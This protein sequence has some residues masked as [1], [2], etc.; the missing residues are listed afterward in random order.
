MWRK[1][2]SRSVTAPAPAFGRGCGER[3]RVLEQGRSPS[4][5]YLLKPWLQQ[6]G[7]AVEALDSREPP[8]AGQIEAGDRVVIARYLPTAWRKLLDGRRE[9]LAGLA[10]FMDDDLFDAALLRELPKGYAQKIRR[11]A[12][13]HRNWFKQVRAELWVSTPVLA[14]KY[15]AWSPVLLPMAPTVALMQRRRSVRIAYH[16][17]ASH[18][19]EIEWL[20]GVL[21]QVLAQRPQVH[22]ELFGDITVHR[23]YRELPRVAVLH[24]MSW[25]NYLAYTASHRCDIGLAP[26]RPGRFNAARGPTK[27]WDYTRMGAAGLYADAVPYAGFVRD[28]VD[29]LLVGHEARAWVERIIELVDDAPLRASLSAAARERVLG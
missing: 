28:G 13:D 10:Y 24:P 17:T 16:G 2:L 21:S 11:L 15:A 26:L 1:L 29:G 12:T 18:I 25:E 5:D 8:R 7:F 6:R 19:G 3:V 9:Q 23:W 20:H 22:A 14:E 27:F 4:G